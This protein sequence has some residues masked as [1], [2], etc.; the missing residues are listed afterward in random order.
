[1]ASRKRIKMD[2]ILIVDDDKFMCQSLSYLLKEEGY[3]VNTAFDG[4]DALSK[5]KKNKCDVIVIDYNLSGLHGLTGLGVLEKVNQTNPSI[6][7]IMISGYGDNNVKSKARKIGVDGFLDKPFRLTKLL[8]TIGSSVNK[9]RKKTASAPKPA[10]KS[11]RVHL[12]KNIKI[13][14]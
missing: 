6:R 9:K 13:S 2:N 12:R 10:L 5:L 8:K 14:S 11:D 3:H 1:M 4:E 7:S